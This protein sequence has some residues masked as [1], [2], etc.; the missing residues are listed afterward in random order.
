MENDQVMLIMPYVWDCLK[1]LKI[2]L[3]NADYVYV[4]H[5]IK[6]IKK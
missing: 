2:G 1:G 5:W 4:T 3:I 6:Y